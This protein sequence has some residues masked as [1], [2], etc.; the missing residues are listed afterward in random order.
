[1]AR[2]RTLPRF[3]PTVG[4]YAGVVLASLLLFLG[5]GILWGVLRPGYTATVVENGTQIELSTETNVE[6]AA[7]GI[8][9]IASLVIG[10][11]IAV[12]T[13]V[14]SPNTRSIWMLL[15]VGLWAFL[16]AQLFIYA[17]EWISHVLHGVGGMGDL[18]DGD[19][20]KYVPNFSPGIVAHAVA[21]FWAVLI[22]WC[23]IVVGSD[24]EEHHHVDGAETP[25]PTSS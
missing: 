23:C 12:V 10:C 13:Y 6:F 24:S 14:K 9:V 18:S 3:S 2:T 16:G 19:T 7:F 15:W 21:P 1:M 22:Y 25:L 4:A 20:V 8:F 5:T 11:A 17:G